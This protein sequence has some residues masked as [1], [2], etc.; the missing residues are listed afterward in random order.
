MKKNFQPVFKRDLEFALKKR[1][2]YE[3]ENGFPYFLILKQLVY[4]LSVYITV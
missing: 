1:L 4:P 3:T 2:S